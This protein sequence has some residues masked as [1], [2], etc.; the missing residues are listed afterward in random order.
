MN[1]IGNVIKTLRCNLG[2]AAIDTAKDI[3]TEKYLYLIEKGER[4]PSVE[5]TRFIGTRLG[6]DLFA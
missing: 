4:I 2:L 6:T 3:C 1:H 5:I